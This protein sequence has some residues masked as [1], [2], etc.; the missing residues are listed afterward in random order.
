MRATYIWII[1][2]VLVVVVAGILV[3]GL[4]WF[5]S[6]KADVQEQ[7]TDPVAEVVS[8]E[9]EHVRFIGPV[10][11]NLEIAGDVI[12]AEQG[13]VFRLEFI[14]GETGKIDIWVNANL[15][16]TATLLS[17]EGTELGRSKI[18]ANASSLF[19]SKTLEAGTYTFRLINQDITL[20]NPFE[21]KF[22]FRPQVADE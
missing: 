8:P 4:G 21:A 11:T 12:R 22:V 20:D 3:F 9:P 10:S 2:S 5:S 15:S 18:L 7:V 13:G 14:L 1:A 19:T 6:D 16:L 17:S